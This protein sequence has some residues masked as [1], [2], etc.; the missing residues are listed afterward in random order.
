MACVGV[1][2]F[3]KN[4]EYERIYFLKLCIDGLENLRQNYKKLDK[5]WVEFEF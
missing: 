5:I 1:W 2:F 3:L 4:Y